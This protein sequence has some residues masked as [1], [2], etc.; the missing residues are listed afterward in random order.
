MGNVSILSACELSK[1]C[2]ESMSKGLADT[3]CCI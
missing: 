3:V 1:D 2:P